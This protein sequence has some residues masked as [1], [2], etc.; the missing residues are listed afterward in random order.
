M[1]EAEF[2]ME[3]I[4][5]CVAVFTAAPVV[6]EFLQRS[7]TVV[8]NRRGGGLSPVISTSSSS[9]RPVGDGVIPIYVATTSECSGRAE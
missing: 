2:H 1:L 5:Q 9:P 7:L 6:R 8:T 3:S 4:D